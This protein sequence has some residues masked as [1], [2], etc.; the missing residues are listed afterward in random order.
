MWKHLEIPEKL[1]AGLYVCSIN[2][3]KMGQMWKIF[4]ALIV[5]YFILDFFAAKNKI[6]LEGFWT[7][8]IMPRIN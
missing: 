4:G 7:L 5:V 2:D 3:D 6:S 1:F 8:M